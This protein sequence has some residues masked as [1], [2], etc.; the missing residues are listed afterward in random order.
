M[1]SLF[2]RPAAPEPQ[3]EAALL[4]AVSRGIVQGHGA[5]WAWRHALGERVAEIGRAHV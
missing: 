3:D 2:R 5:A 1:F 4:Q